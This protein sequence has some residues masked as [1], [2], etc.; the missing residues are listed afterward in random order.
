VAG[1]TSARERLAHQLHEAR[2][3]AGLSGAQLAERLGP[4]WDQPRVSKIER[5]R[6]IPTEDAIRRWATATGSRVEQLL[7][8]RRRASDEYATLRDLYATAGGPEQLQDRLAAIEAAST[9]ITVYSPTVIL[10]LL[11][12][13]AYA[14]ELLHRPPGAI[15][16]GASDDEI[17]RMV[18]ARLRRQAILYEPGRQIT[19]LMSEAALRSRYV[20]HATLRDQLLHL[21]RTAETIT[22]ATIGV[23][24]FSADLPLV[25]LHGWA[26]RDDVVT[27]EHAGGDLEIGDPDQVERYA[28]WTATL[29]E[30]ALVHSEAATLARKIA[31]ETH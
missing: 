13:P 22:T 30:I 14:H 31:A 17:G 24:P 26:I 11:Q 6:R 18:A 9:R 12:T 28:A 3:R 16:A 21:A 1:P 23:V 2:R 7:D 20:S 15:E 29:L 27:L 25:T 10:G 8:L 4:G 5:G 19:L